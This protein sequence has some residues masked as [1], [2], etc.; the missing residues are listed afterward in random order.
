MSCNF[1][2]CNHHA[3]PNSSNGPIVT[4]N[5]SS[6]P[7]RNSVATNTSTSNFYTQKTT[8][9]PQVLSDPRVIYGTSHAGS[10][11]YSR[12]G[13]RLGRQLSGGGGTTIDAV[14]FPRG[15]AF[16]TCEGRRPS[17]DGANRETRGYFPA[18][19]VRNTSHRRFVQ[20]LRAPGSYSCTQV[21]SDCMRFDYAGPRVPESLRERHDEV[22]LM[23][24][25]HNK[26]APH[27]R[28][29]ATRQ[30]IS[31]LSGNSAI[32]RK[33][34]RPYPQK[35][36]TEGK[37]RYDPPSSG[38]AART[39]AEMP[40]APAARDLYAADE[41]N[42]RAPL[43][44]NEAENFYNMGPGFKSGFVQTELGLSPSVDAKRA[45]GGN[46]RNT[47]KMTSPR[48]N[49]VAFS[50]GGG[51]GGGGYGSS[52][53]ARAALSPSTIKPT[54]L[55]YDHTTKEM[56]EVNGEPLAT[57]NRQT[58]QATASRRPGSA[59]SQRETVENKQLARPSSANDVAA[60]RR[61]YYP[62]GVHSIRR[63]FYDQEIIGGSNHERG[64]APPVCDRC[65]CNCCCEQDCSNYDNDGK[66]TAT[67]GMMMSNN[68][69]RHRPGATPDCLWW[70]GN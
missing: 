64:G 36:L 37:R 55:T 30:K 7:G 43:D 10:R 45:N 61:K 44:E 26:N 38:Q 5:T 28:T 3:R 21:A 49:V 15:D 29:A 35:H 47:Q 56:V 63:H 24:K 25:I 65:C 16:V 31:A 23:N 59:H 12:N 60:W 18:N 52:N 4:F 67:N 9:T 33:K 22:T 48:K 17:P 34:Q 2:S 57:I 68:S 66:S 11:I 50:S 14:V 53:P 32:S 51:G 54:R 41:L 20:S 13:E 42:L 6:S 58:R 39:V 27:V 19:L 69:A 46:Q 70:Y 40:I 1:C 62:D 8:Q